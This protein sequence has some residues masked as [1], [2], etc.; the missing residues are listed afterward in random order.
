MKLI[1]VLVFS[2]F[3]VSCQD[4]NEERELEIDKQLLNIRVSDN[5]EIFGTWTMCSMY[6][7][8]TSIQMNTC[9]E[10]TF[11]SNG[12]EILKG[13]AN[14][15]NFSWTLREGTL[16]ILNIGSNSIST[17]RDTTYL[18]FFDSVENHETLTVSLLEKSFAYYLTR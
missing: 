7:N 2:F 8:L 1:S 16:K 11:N 3:I 6:S 5:S 18:A 12:M 17:F 15:E 4:T 13:S 14:T 9:A 10:I